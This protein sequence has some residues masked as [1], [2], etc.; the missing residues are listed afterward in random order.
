[1]YFPNFI[2]LISITN[3]A[4][5]VAVNTVYIYNVYLIHLR[6]NVICVEMAAVVIRKVF[7]TSSWYQ[8]RLRKNIEKRYISPDPISSKAASQVQRTTRRTDR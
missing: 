7:W 4:A 6:N 5:S 2:A 1:M 3:G 8:E